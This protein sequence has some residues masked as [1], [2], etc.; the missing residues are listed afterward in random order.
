MLEVVFL[1]TINHGVFAQE[2]IL[3]GDDKIVNLAQEKLKVDRRGLELGKIEVNLEVKC[4][5]LFVS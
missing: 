5:N 3:K 2:V 1:E 4:Q